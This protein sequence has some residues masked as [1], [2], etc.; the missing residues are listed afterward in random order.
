MKKILAFAGSNSKNSINKKLL[1][2]VVGRIENH[3]VKVLELNDYEFPMFG[4][5]HENEK[6]YPADIQVLKM[7]IKEVD[8]LVIAVNEHNGGPSAY[9]KN[10]TDWLSRMELKFLQDKKVLLMST[11][12]GKRGAASSLEY[13]KNV[14]PRFGAEVVESFSLPSFNENF[15]VEN[16]KITDEILLLGLNDV[17]SNFEQELQE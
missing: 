10:I 6:G 16:H 1:N 17:V 9:F 8:A 5:D 3:E 4:V 12:P 7:L 15:D 11:S 14:L 2:Y 13:Y